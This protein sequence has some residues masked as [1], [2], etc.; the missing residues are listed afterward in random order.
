LIVSLVISGLLGVDPPH[1]S[2]FRRFGNASLRRVVAIAETLGLNQTVPS[3]SSLPAWPKGSAIGRVLEV[4]VTPVTANR[5][6]DHSC[7]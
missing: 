7:H 1:S 4:P 3:G 2:Y 5:D 6:E